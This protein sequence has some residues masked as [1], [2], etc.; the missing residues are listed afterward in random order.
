[1]WHLSTQVNNGLLASYMT[2]FYPRRGKH[3]RFITFLV[4]ALVY[5]SIAS[6]L[7]TLAT[8]IPWSDSVHIPTCYLFFEETPLR[9]IQDSRNWD[10]N[11]LLPSVKQIWVLAAP[12][13]VDLGVG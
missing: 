7:V 5:R 8:L 1:M 13:A 10:T 2:D 9:L 11:K 3:R 4:Y 6:N 12:L